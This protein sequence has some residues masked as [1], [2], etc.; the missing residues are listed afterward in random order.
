MDRLSNII[1]A[2]ND[3]FGNID[4]KDR[5]RIEQIVSEEIPQKVAADK[6]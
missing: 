3:Q 4:W 6:A 5:D 2:F 1:K